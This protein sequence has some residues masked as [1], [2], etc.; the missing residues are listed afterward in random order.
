L[1][2]DRA[3]IGIPLSLEKQNPREVRALL[4]AAHCSLPNRQRQF[5]KRPRLENRAKW[6]NGGHSRDRTVAPAND[7]RGAIPPCAKTAR[8]EVRT[9]RKDRHPALLMLPRHSDT[10]ELTIIYFEIFIPYPRARPIIAAAYD[11]RPRVK[12]RFYCRYVYTCNVYI[13]THDVYTTCISPQMVLPRSR[14]LAVNNSQEYVTF[15]HERPSTD[16]G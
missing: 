2:R 4:V 9:W 5:C 13:C 15:R 16:H 10:I 1:S 6:L 7:T 11:K 3:A 14:T 8:L 12:N